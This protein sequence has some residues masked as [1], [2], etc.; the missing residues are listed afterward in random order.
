MGDVHDIVCELVQFKN[1]NPTNTHPKTRIPRPIR[2]QFVLSEDQLNDF[3]T[4]QDISLKRMNYLA[5]EFHLVVTNTGRVK[6]GDRIGYGL[7]RTIN[8]HISPTPS[9]FQG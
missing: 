6:K 3:V 9:R 2:Q 5:N 4:A 7:S 1:E 8:K